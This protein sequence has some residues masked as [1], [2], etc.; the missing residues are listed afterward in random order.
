MFVLVFLCCAVLCRQRPIL[1][2]RIPTKCQE[3]RFRNLKKGKPI[4]VSP[5]TEERGKKE[6]KAVIT[7]DRTEIIYTVTY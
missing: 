5:R 6:R 7:A 4:L 3:T 1:R 2:S